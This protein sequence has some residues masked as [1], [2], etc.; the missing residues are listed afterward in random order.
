MLQNT[1]V[2]II[3]AWPGHGCLGACLGPGLMALA[4]GLS[5]G[6]HR[7]YQAGRP[8]ISTANSKRLFNCAGE[9]MIKEP[10]PV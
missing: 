8:H 1:H 4:L 9:H 6:S 3:S 10:F 5:Y 7:S 2:C